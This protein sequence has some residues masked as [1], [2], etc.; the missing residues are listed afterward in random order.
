MKR[1]V[2]ILYTKS[3]KG[4]HYSDD[5]RG[6]HPTVQNGTVDRIACTVNAQ[7]F[8]AIEYNIKVKNCGTFSV[9]Y[10]TKTA[11]R[12][13]AFCF[14]IG[15]GGESPTFVPP[16]PSVFPIEVVEQS[17][18]VYSRVHFVCKFEPS[19]NTS[20]KDLHYQLFWYAKKDGSE[21]MFIMSEQPKDNLDKLQLTEEIFMNEMKQTLGAEVTVIRSKIIRGDNA[22]PGKVSLTST[23]PIGCEGR[24]G[25]ARAIVAFV[26]DMCG[27]PI[28][29]G[30][31]GTSIFSDRW[32][33][34]VYINIVAGNDAAY[35][36]S[37]K[38]DIYLRTDGHIP[39]NP[40]LNFRYG[41][42][43]LPIL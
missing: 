2:P 31:C 18:D 23:I 4:P 30:Y 25:C 14:G 22:N 24:F 19:N 5:I 15:T 38:F 42:F 36:L 13:E 39:P 9:Y 35:S 7:S 37:G 20:D 16:T 17:V 29:Q 10:L 33:S 11:S 34:S 27:G 12:Q 21:V 41:I 32:N 40:A 26:P 8:C 6:T 1:Q 28:F 43:S 3:F